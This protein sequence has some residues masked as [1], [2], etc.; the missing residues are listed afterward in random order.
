MEKIQFAKDD[1]F[2]WWDDEGRSHWKHRNE[3]HSEKNQE[4]V[5]GNAGRNDPRA[6]GYL[7]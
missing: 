2:E 1:F 7:L 5:Q 6:S 3:E 4:K